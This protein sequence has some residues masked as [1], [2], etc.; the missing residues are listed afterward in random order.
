MDRLYRLYHFTARNYLAG[1]ILAGVKPSYIEIPGT[2][3]SVNQIVSL[4]IDPDPT[5]MIDKSLVGP[6]PLSSTALAAWRAAN[7]TAPTN[8]PVYLPWT[9]EFRIAI[10]IP[11]TD[12]NLYQF[13]LQYVA[14]LGFGSQSSF[15]TFL[16][17][18]GGTPNNW[19]AYLG[20]IPVSYI[21]DIQKV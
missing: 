11:D 19:Y 15:V 12:S 10:D 9:S 14:A 6:N 3:K 17:E 7:P 20:V 5:A 2:G 8:L 16:R 18:G 13:D 21:V 1:I 4:T